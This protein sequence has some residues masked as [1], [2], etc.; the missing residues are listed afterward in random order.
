[1]IPILRKTR[2]FTVAGMAAGTLVTAGLVGQL[3]T[4]QDKSAAAKV[5]PSQQASTGSS[6]PTAS[7]SADSSSGS[8]GSSSS[9]SGSYSSVPSVNAGGTGGPD[10]N[11]RGS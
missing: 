4:H 11:T 1:M 8:S 9:S 10:S 6:S 5:T 2:R 7:S 3:A